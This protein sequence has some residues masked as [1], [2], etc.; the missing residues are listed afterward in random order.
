MVPV[1]N[2]ANVG[3]RTL[4]PEAVARGIL[5]TLRGDTDK[6]IYTG[7]NWNRRFREYSERSK[8]RSFALL[9]KSCASCC[10]S[11]AAR[12]FPSANAVCRERNSMGLVTGELAE[13]LHLTE[14]FPA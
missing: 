2:A 12:N 11:A 5:E 10:S 13:V 9:R 4:T 6:T 3:L 7:Q 14:D 1:N 8:V